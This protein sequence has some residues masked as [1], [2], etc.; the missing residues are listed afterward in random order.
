MSKK[1]KFDEVNSVLVF[2]DDNQ[3]TS[4]T[5]T[6]KMLD[7][8]LRS[9]GHD[10]RFYCVDTA[11]D[12]PTGAERVFNPYTEVADLMMLL[13]DADGTT[14]ILEVG[15]DCEG[16]LFRYAEPLGGIK[17]KFSKLL[18][19]VALFA[20]CDT[21][22]LGAKLLSFKQNGMDPADISIIFTRVIT[23]PGMPLSF[24]AQAQFEYQVEAQYGEYFLPF[25]RKLGARIITEDFLPEHPLIKAS[26]GKEWNPFTVG[27]T[28]DPE[29]V[30]RRKANPKDPDIRTEWTHRAA[31]PKVVAQVRNVFDLALS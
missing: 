23:D 15:G 7:S 19:L 20:K 22:K 4:K 3:H 26:H 21:N 1:Q 11:T 27:T 31:A 5:A 28:K 14:T 8:Y 2:S 18:V 29:F 13:D 30:A 24:T 17:E 25:A 16:P 12:V 6:S 10:S 9:L